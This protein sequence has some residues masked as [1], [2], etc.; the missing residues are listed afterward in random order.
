MSRIEILGNSEVVSY[1][2]DLEVFEVGSL[3][4]ILTDALAEPLNG[5][6]IPSG[7]YRLTALITLTKE[8]ESEATAIIDE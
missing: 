6:N 8:D 2:V 5:V 4:K 1:Q 7:K 3:R